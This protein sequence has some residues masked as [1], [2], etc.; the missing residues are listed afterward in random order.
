MPLFS[1]ISGST[2]PC[3]RVLSCTERRASPSYNLP[4]FPHRTH[5][6]YSLDRVSMNA[7]NARKSQRESLGAIRSHGY[8]RPA[9]GCSL[10]VFRCRTPAQLLYSVLNHRYQRQLRIVICCTLWPAA[11]VFAQLTS[12]AGARYEVFAGGELE[13][14]VRYLQLLGLAHSYPWSIRAFSQPELDRLLPAEIAHPWSSSVMLAANNR[15]GAHVALTPVSLTTRYNSR[16]PYGMNDGPLWAGRGAS[17]DMYAGIGMRWGP[18]SGALNP[19]WAYAQNARFSLMP[20]GQTGALQYA[21]GQFPTLVDLPQRFGDSP[22]SKLYPGN[23]YVRLDLLGG[24]MEA[25][26]AD[27]WWGPSYEYPYILGN[28]APGFRHVSIGTEFPL[29]VFVGKIHGKVEWGELDQS[30]YSS[31][32]G[33]AARRFMSGVVAEFLPRGMDGLEIGAVRFFHQPWPADG[34]SAHNFLKPLE[35]FFKKNVANVDTLKDNQLGELF[36]RWRLPHSAFEFYGEYGRDDHSYN[37]RDLVLQPDHLAAYTLGFAKV[38][39]DSGGT[40][41]RVLR[42]EMI[43]FEAN[44]MMMSRLEGVT[45]LNNDVRQGHTEDGQFLGADVGLGSASGSTVAFES[46]NTRGRWTVSWSRRVR[47]EVAA[48]TPPFPV[49]SRGPDVQHSLGLELLRFCRYG[50][51][52]AGATAVYEFNRDFA[53]DAFNLNAR[54]GWRIQAR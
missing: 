17:M 25:S 50:D 2:R 3:A 14:Y 42:A 10:C 47:R 28:N 18:F 44:T 46:Y 36:F 7:G 31:V 16:F 20:N 48:F 30:Q 21:D 27:Q 5:G 29:D 9:V 33:T 8:V 52:V 40:A 39:P 24:S 23:S 53:S 51:V 26:T 32:S 19:E 43:N 11:S 15:T 54:I 49:A 37:A 6:C 34:L 41:F 38:W 22:Y 4:R 13:R 45:Y 1:S 35:A 12:A